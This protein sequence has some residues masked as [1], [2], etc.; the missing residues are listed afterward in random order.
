MHNSSRTNAWLSRV[1]L[2]LVGNVLQISFFGILATALLRNKWDL[3]SGFHWRVE[4]VAGMQKSRLL[5]VP[6]Q[7]LLLIDG[8]II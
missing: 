7:S 2:L 8:E 6:L 1:I 4:Q 3:P 5:K